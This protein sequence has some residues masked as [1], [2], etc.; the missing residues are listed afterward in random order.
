MRSRYARSVTKR[1]LRAVEPDAPAERLTVEQLAQA[2]G[3]TVRNIRNHQSRG[4]LPPP[5]VVARV[6]YYGPEHVERLRLIREMQADGFN[7][8][9][10]KRLLTSG[11]EQLAGV[12]RALATP[13][14]SETPEILTIEELTERF[15]PLDERNL[16]KAQKLEWLVPLG[17]GRYEA[18]S[19]SLLRAA[20]AALASGV[21]LGTALGVVERVKQNCESI[22]RTFVRM[23]MEELWRPLREDP[24]REERWPEVVD[25][26]ERLRPVAS[27]TVLAVFKQTMATEIERA[28]SK[29]LERQARRS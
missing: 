24:Q 1:T 25:A 28:F 26:I 13:F 6:G 23:F 12:R 22:S 4:L 11:A 29:E 19:P 3:M 27:E 18:P 5:D 17:D 10:I 21:S 7:L 8:S 2:T 14:E 20:D 9:A 15:G 16:A